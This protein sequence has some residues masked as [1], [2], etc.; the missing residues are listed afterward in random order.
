[1]GRKRRT[2]ERK[3]NR[4]GNRRVNVKIKLS[5]YLKQII[6]ADPEI[7]VKGSTVLECLEDLA[8]LYPQ[9]KEVL[10]DGRGKVQLRWMIYLDDK[11]LLNSS[12]LSSPV[13]GD[14]PVIG[15]Y[16]IIAGG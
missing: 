8:G 11:P 14:N 13:R 15:I 7:E 12:A 6:K 2:R 10:F 3:T 1:M 16:P 5:G 9:I 4:T